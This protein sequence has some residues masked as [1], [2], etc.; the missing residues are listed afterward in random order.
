MAIL[1]L[2]IKKAFDTISLTYIWKVL[3]AYGFGPRFQQWLKLS[4]NDVE[5]M[6]ITNCYFTQSFP[7]NR[8]VRQGCSLSPLLYVLCVE[9]LANIILSD[10]QIKGT[11]LPD[12]GQVKLCYYADDVSGFL[13]D[14]NFSGIWLE[15]LPRWEI[16]AE[17]LGICP[18]VEYI[19]NA[20]WST[21]VDRI[22][23]R[24]QYALL[25]YCNSLLFGL[26]KN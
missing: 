9:S 16:N 15:N 14:L 2:D 1:N 25:D 7:I 11:Y 24:I 12:S 4:Y 8:G 19:D 13:A 20:N 23:K 22:D 6:V 5:A 17:I 3:T 18:G 21:L 10:P 26:P